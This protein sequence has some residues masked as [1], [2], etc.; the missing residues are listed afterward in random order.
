MR[1]DLPGSA[2]ELPLW[3]LEAVLGEMLPGFESVEVRPRIR[4]AKCTQCNTVRPITAS[5]VPLWKEQ[6]GE[7]DSFYC[8]CRGWD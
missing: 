7:F 3:Q 5:F 4:Y 6:P 1:D 8:G 2:P